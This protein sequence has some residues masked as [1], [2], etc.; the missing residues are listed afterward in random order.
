M[1]GHIASKKLD[2]PRWRFM[3]DVSPESDW[4]VFCKVRYCVPES[5][6]KNAVIP[7]R[8]SGKKQVLAELG[9]NP[10]EQLF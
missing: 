3:A 7:L 5:C 2:F 4:G 10:S 6:R 1:I 8:S 9:K